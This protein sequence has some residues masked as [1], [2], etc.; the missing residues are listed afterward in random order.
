MFFIVDGGTM[1][2]GYNADDRHRHTVHVASVRRDAAAVHGGDQSRS[3]SRR[4]DGHM[5]N[6]SVGVLAV[7]S[8]SSN[9]GGPIY[10]LGAVDQYTRRPGGQEG[11]LYRVFGDVIGPIVRL[12]LSL[13]H[14]G[15]YRDRTGNGAWGPN[16]P[17]SFL[18]QA[19]AGC[20]PGRMPFRV[21]HKAP[22]ARARVR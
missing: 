13:P 4:Y 19:L 18:K 1:T 6:Q 11:R 8:S 10:A 22:A 2:I 14:T 20:A 17:T 12:V 5:E 16:G 3:S 7:G 9:S 15:R 21:S